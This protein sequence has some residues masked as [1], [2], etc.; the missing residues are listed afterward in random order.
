[1]CKVYENDEK[2]IRANLDYCERMVEVWDDPDEKKFWRDAAE[3][4]RAKLEA[5]PENVKK[6]VRAAGTM[7]RNFT[8]MKEATPDGNMWGWTWQG[9]K[10]RSFSLSD[11]HSWVDRL[12][13]TRIAAETTNEKEALI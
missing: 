5:S 2:C 4:F 12:I 9:N 10:Y 7:Y 8:A 13:E 3:G 1:M 11:F 6:T